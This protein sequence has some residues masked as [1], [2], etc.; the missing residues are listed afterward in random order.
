MS[1][2]A[3][4]VIFCA[5]FSAFSGTWAYLAFTKPRLWLRPRGN[6]KYEEVIMDEDFTLRLRIW[7]AIATL[8]FLV[9]IVGLVVNVPKLLG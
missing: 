6:R 3:R 5:L 1:E 8:C 2:A 4:T 7:G 9:G